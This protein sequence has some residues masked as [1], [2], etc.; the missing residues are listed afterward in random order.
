MIENLKAAKKESFPEGKGLFQCILV[1]IMVLMVIAVGGVEQ[2]HPHLPVQEE[3]RQGDC[4]KIQVLR[5]YCSVGGTVIIKN[6][7]GVKQNQVVHYNSSD[8]W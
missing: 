5:H 3:S 1:Y 4:E 8:L 2:E 7:V 6:N